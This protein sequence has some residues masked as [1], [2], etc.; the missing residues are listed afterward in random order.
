MMHRSNEILHMEG[1]QATFYVYI[2]DRNDQCWQ[3]TKS[4]INVLNTHAN[5]YQYFYLNFVIMQYV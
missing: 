3:V 5:D 2:I 4:K 1:M